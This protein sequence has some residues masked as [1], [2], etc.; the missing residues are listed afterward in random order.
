MPSNPNRKFQMNSAMAHLLLFLSL[1]STACADLPMYLG[2]TQSA[3]MTHAAQETN[4]DSVVYTTP[5]EF[6]K[7]H[8]FYQGAG[9]EIAGELLLNEDLKRATFTTA[10]Q[11]LAA[12]VTCVQRSPDPG[13]VITYFRPAQKDRA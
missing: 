4:P 8:A 11:A 10:G 13:T 9:T 12:R 1:S 7:V 6:D 3:S 5:D 2:A